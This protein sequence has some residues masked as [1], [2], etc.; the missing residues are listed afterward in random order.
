[1]M[2]APVMVYYWLPGDNDESEHPNVFHMQSVDK[3]VKLRDIRS[4]FPLPGSY[5][6]RFK[7]KWEQ[8]AVWMDVTNEDS[9]VPLFDDKIFAKV[10][11]VTWDGQANGKASGAPAPAAQPA[12]AAAAA[13]PAPQPTATAAAAPAPAPQADLLNHAPAPQADLLNVGDTSLL[14]GLSSAPK[15]GDDFDPF[16]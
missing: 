2:G 12:P 8:N 13:P 4:K 14:G 5:H 6:F 9:S 3:A 7:M 16:F 1:M 15:K 10:L 11:R